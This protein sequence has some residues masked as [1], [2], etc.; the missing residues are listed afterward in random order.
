MTAD[1]RPAVDRLVVA[2]AAAYGSLIAVPAALANVILADQVPKPKS[3]LNATLLVLIL[4][5]AVAG[6]AAG[7]EA[8]FRA[9]RH[10]ARG[11]LVAAVPVEVIG[12]L[13]RADRGDGIAP[14]TIVLVAVLAV[15]AGAYGSRLGAARRARLL[16]KEEPS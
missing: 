13:G 15:G 14:G 8:A 10:G 3:A 1:P 4:G 2:R 6:I 7:R 11:G 12:A 5:F 9:A 16:A